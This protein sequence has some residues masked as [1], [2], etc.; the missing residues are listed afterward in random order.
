MPKQTVKE[1][2]TNPNSVSVLVCW[3]IGVQVCVHVFMYDTDCFVRVSAPV[4]V[5]IARSG[6]MKVLS[7]ANAV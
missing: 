1:V 2:K 6:Y 3:A 5:W 7:I 4:V